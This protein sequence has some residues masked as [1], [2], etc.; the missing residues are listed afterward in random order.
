[1]RTFRITECTV[2]N[3]N[4]LQKKKNN[5]LDSITYGTNNAVNEEEE[6]HVLILW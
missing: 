5:E 3:L 1:M 6:Y 2:N 4:L